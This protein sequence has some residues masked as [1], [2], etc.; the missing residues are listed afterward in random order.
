MRLFFL[1]A[2]FTTV[3]LAHA[4]QLP[5]NEDGKIE[6]TDVVQVDSANEQTLFSRARIFVARSFSAA[7]D[8]TVVEDANTFTL[9]AKGLLPRNYTSRL[10][11]DFGGQVR[12]RLIIQCRPGRY[13]YVMTDF[14][15]RDVI[16]RDYSGGA[17][18]RETPEC[19]R[20]A[21][22]RKAWKDIKKRY[23]SARAAHRCIITGGDAR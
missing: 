11:R 7:N 9:I 19:G 1:I 14:V 2:L 4:Q 12:F 20:L 17:L 18:E 15:H 3:R 6:F 13:R 21:I 22:S 16:K 23:G 8:V 10:N 5:V